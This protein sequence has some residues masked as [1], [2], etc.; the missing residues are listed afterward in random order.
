ML[1][2]SVEVLSEDSQA[3][4]QRLPVRFHDPRCPPPQEIR[5]Q[6]VHEPNFRYLLAGRSIVT[7]VAQSYAALLANFAHRF[8]M[9]KGGVELAQP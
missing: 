7:T 1:V 3:L 2:A 9:R 4:A 8:P 6:G 5:A